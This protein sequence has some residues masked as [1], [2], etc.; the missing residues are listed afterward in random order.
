MPLTAKIVVLLALMESGWMLFD[1]TRALIKG[2]YITPSTGS[3]AGELGPWK[4]VVKLAGIEPRSTLMKSI[5][6]VYGAAWLAILAC[7]VGRAPWARGAM[8]AAAAGSLWY[9]PI[10]TAF[11][12]VQLILLLVAR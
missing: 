11:G 12:I 3:H 9:L 7:F 8:I 4:H 5:F 6:V 10:G 1:G 2:D